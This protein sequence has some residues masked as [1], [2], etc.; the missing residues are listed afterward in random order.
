MAMSLFLSQSALFCRDQCRSLHGS[1]G[2]R[3]ACTVGDPG[4]IPGSGRSPK[5]GREWLPTPVPLPGA[6]H[7]QRLLS[8]GLQKSQM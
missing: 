3:S 6:F 1:D 8:M 4:L 7:G 5:K 2:E